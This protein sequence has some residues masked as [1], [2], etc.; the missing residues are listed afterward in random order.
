MFIW[1]RGVFFLQ[2]PGLVGGEGESSR[3]GFCFFLT[4]RAKLYT[5]L[6]I[7]F[8]REYWRSLYRTGALCKCIYLYKM[9]SQNL[10]QPILNFA[11]VNIDFQPE[12]GVR[13]YFTVFCGAMKLPKLP[14]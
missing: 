6:H 14:G 3:T 5:I 12:Q 2:L 11:D 4:F 9:V 13:I 8:R 10:D 1:G 7:Y